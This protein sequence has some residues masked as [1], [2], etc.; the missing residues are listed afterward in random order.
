MA[1][2]VKQLVNQKKIAPYEDAKRSIH[3]EVSK[4]DL[5]RAKCFS[6]DECVLAK[7]TCRAFPNVLK[8]WFY[9]NGV[10]VAFADP[11]TGKPT[12]TIRYMPSP[13]AKKN[14]GTFDLS[15]K[16]LPG[17]YRLDPPEG[18]ATLKAIRKRGKKRPGRHQP[19]GKGPTRTPRH[20]VQPEKKSRLQYAYPY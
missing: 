14:I 18:S 19:T 4:L 2:K 8:A 16:F 17:T 1:T 5:K 11:K 3:I 7:A 13:E 9:K 6:P 15:R 20:V 10:Y 12:K